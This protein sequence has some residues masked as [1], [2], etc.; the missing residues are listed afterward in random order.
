MKIFLFQRIKQVSYNY[1]PEGGLAIV[2]KDKEHAL[3]LIEQDEYINI[4]K[5]EWNEVIVYNL[6]DDEE[7]RVFVFPDAGC[8]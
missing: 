4:S 6:S 5:E 1:H 7:P 8:C 3:K 2:A